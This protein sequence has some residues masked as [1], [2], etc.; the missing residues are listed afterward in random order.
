MT[1]C[2]STLYCLAVLLALAR[3]APNIIQ[4]HHRDIFENMEDIEIK[5]VIDSDNQD[6]EDF[7]ILGG[8]GYSQ[9][10]QD[11][12]MPVIYEDGVTMVEEVTEDGVTMVEEVTE[13]SE[14]MVDEDPEGKDGT[15][16]ETV[17]GGAIFEDIGQDT[18][19]RSLGKDMKYLDTKIKSDEIGKRYEIDYDIDSMEEADNDFEWNNQLEELQKVEQNSKITLN[20]KS[21]FTPEVEDRNKQIYKGTN[22]NDISDENTEELND[23]EEINNL[24]VSDINEKQ[25]LENMPQKILAEESDTV[26]VTNI[27]QI[28]EIATE[29]KELLEAN[30]YDTFSVSNLDEI[31]EVTAIEATNSITKDEIK[32]ETTIITRNVADIEEIT[33]VEN[34]LNNSTDTRLDDIIAVNAGNDLEKE[35]SNEGESKN[36]D[37]EDIVIVTQ[38]VSGGEVFKTENVILI[39]L[40][41]F[42]M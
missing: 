35:K 27:N 2:N 31:K 38:T 13:D 17:E 39:F 37:E 30:G 16:V 28:N 19:E 23:T 34:T 33:D 25:I 36:N 15:E 8:F 14:T 7:Q 40:L 22:V 1:R 20:E 32:P 9:S 26:P 3:S 6:L 29:S 5:D 11:F 18:S 21:L 42:I 4:T 12:D 41:A 10:L 24:L